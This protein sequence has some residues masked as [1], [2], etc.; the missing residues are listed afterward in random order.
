MAEQVAVKA[1]PDAEESPAA[2]PAPMD[3]DDLYEDAGDLEFYDSQEQGQ[4]FEKLYLSRVPRYL[5][6]AWHQL[7]EGLGDDDEVQIGTIRTWDTQNPDGSNSV[8]ICKAH[9][10]LVLSSE[11]WAL[12]L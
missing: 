2:L 1:E 3:E 4:V 5:W 7:V 11:I 8:R 10:Y 9:E 12:I 6:D